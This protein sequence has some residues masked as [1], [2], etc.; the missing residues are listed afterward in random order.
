MN[1]S[2]GVITAESI[3]NSYTNEDLEAMFVKFGQVKFPK[4]IAA[5]ICEF[6]MSKRITNS[7]ELSDI[8]EHALPSMSSFR[9]KIKE[10]AR[11]FQALRIVT[12]N[13]VYLLNN[14]ISFVI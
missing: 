4:P 12:N 9:L 3:I 11:A 7:V 6:R 8:I 10:K 2:D 5:R 14:P 13:E 1:Q